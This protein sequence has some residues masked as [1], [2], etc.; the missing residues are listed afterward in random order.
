M[1]S[2]RDCRCDRV[3]LYINERKQEQKQSEN[4]ATT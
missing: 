4:F 2:R 3:A 1:K